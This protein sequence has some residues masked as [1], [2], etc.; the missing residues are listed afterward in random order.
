MQAIDIVIE[1]EVPRTF[2]TASLESVF[3]CPIGKK[4]RLEWHV[5]IPSLEDE[6]SIGMIVGPSGS[7]KSTVMKHAYGEPINWQWPADKALID[8]LAPDKEMTE[9]SA[10][11]GAVGL[12]TVPSWA[13]PFHVLSNGEQFRATIA[14]HFLEDERTPIVIDEFTSVVD[15][16]VAQIASNAVQKFI[17]KNNKRF[18]AVTCHYDIIEWLQPDWV[19]DMATRTV[20]VRERRRRPAIEVTLAR[21]PYSLWKTFA[22]YHYMS[23]ELHKAAQCYAAFVHDRPVCIAALLSRPVSS[24]RDKGT[25]I[26]GLSRLVTLPDYQGMGIAFVLADSLGG[27]FAN[28]GQRMNCYPAHPALISS[29]S[30]NNNWIQTTPPGRPRPVSRTATVNR[31]GQACI[32]KG[33]ARPNAVYSYVGPKLDIQL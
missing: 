30:R 1:S 13:R 33:S 24:G 8:A 6:W 25:A 10:A 14:R 2:R 22:P 16:Q 28:R 23:A 20:E 21:V 9:V 7:G 32:V 18:V 4:Q 3:D 12:N 19:L 29:F 27:M 26:H 5:E 15:R 11:L 17:R 31:Q